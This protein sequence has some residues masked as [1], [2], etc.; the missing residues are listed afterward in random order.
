MTH[1][2]WFTGSRRVQPA[3]LATR[4]PP[5][6]YGALWGAA[7]SGDEGAQGEGERGREGG[8]LGESSPGREGE[9]AGNAVS[10][11]GSG[12]VPRPAGEVYRHRLRH[13]QHQQHQQQPLQH[14]SFTLDNQHTL[15]LSHTCP[16]VIPTAT[17]VVQKR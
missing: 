15:D 17:A 6:S 2:G 14:H 13:T 5:S 16:K 11:E 3:A 10:Y 1:D 9:G 8:V 7:A 4:P 12:V